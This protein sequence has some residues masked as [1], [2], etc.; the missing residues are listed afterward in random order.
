[1]PPLKF[2]LSIVRPEKAVTLLDQSFTT[3]SVSSIKIKNSKRIHS[4]R[5]SKVDAAHG[6]GLGPYV[7]SA[8][9]Q[10]P[11]LPAP[12]RRQTGT[13][14]SVQKKPF[15]KCLSRRCFQKL[16]KNNFIKKQQ[17]YTLICNDL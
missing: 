15:R 17:R 1:M 10:G 11:C 4:E 12:P 14:F 9:G 6:G 7:A 16:K 5:T 8:K 2:H 13:R 3:I